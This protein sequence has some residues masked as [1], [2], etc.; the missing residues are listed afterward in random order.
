M[1]QTGVVGVGWMQLAN[2]V[3]AARTFA[4]RDD[5]DELEI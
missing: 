5:L 3:L 2:E 1:D 4:A